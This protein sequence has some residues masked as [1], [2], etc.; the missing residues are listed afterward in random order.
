VTYPS[1]PPPGPQQP[2]YPPQQQPQYPPQQ[3]YP[4]QQPQ[5]P[6][7]QGYY[8]PPPQY[9]PP[10]PPAQQ[11]QT[12][13]DDFYDQPAA[14]GKSIAGW[15]QTPGQSISG[16]IARALTHADTRPQTDMQTKQPRFFGDGRPMVTMTIPLL[17]QPSP[18]FPDGR[19]AWIISSSDREDLDMAMQAAGCKPRTVPEKGALVTITFTG[20]KQIPGFGVP[21]KVKKITYQRPADANGHGNGQAAPAVAVTTEPPFEPPAQQQQQPQY[22]QQALPPQQ[23]GQPQYPNVP[24]GQA[25]QDMVTGNGTQNPYA[26]QPQYQQQAPPQ[27]QMPGAFGQ[28]VPVGQAP[29]P[30][31]YAQDPYTMATG[32]PQNPTG[33][34]PYAT[35]PAPGTAPGTSA[36]PATAS[37]QQQQQFA[38]PADLTPSQAERLRALTGG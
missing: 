22:Q 5:Y 6:P 23:Y 38:A 4:P 35:G 37:N 3:G 1:Y 29:L 19:A 20:L 24:N 34:T 9:A 13:I 17:V 33:Q 8:A 32:Q 30:P 14:S 21:K 26:Q 18:D 11:Q 16:I 25:A 7:Q 2:A 36:A 12:T 15:F 27:L 10:P 28:Q 31:Q